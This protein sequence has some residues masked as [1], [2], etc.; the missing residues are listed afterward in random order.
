[1][2]NLLSADEAVLGTSGTIDVQ[3]EFSKI[4]AGL[5][6]SPASVDMRIDWQARQVTYVQLLKFSTCDH[7]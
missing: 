2:L 6:L 3:Y 5:K 1:M 7:T 4:S